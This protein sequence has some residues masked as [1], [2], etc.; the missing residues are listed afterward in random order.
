MSLWQS[1]MRDGLSWPFL[2]AS[3][4]SGSST[5]PTICGSSLWY[6]HWSCSS[7]SVPPSSPLNSWWG[8]DKAG[9]VVRRRWWKHQQR[10]RRQQQQQQQQRKLPKQ[11]LQSTHKLWKSRITRLRIISMTRKSSRCRQRP[12]QRLQCRRLR[13]SQ[14]PVSIH[15]S[16]YLSFFLSIWNPQDATL[17]IA[18]INFLL[19]LLYFYEQIREHESCNSMHMFFTAEA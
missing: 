7:S 13:F 16:V 5:R 9:H 19:T 15:L 10:R 12:L 17:F 4:S 18:L 6:S 1:C 2:S 14:H 11:N 8:Y 3:Y